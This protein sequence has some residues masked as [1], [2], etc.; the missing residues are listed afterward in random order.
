MGRPKLTDE[1]RKEARRKRERQ[2]FI[3]RSYVPK[4]FWP[5]M[6]NRHGEP[7]TKRHANAIHQNY[8]DY[9][10]ASSQCLALKNILELS[11][12]VIGEIVMPDLEGKSKQGT[13]RSYI[14]KAKTFLREKDTD[15]PEMMLYRFSIKELLKKEWPDKHQNGKAIL[16]HRFNEQFPVDVEDQRYQ[17]AP[18]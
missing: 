9:R 2:E 3:L 11:H 16:E 15:E 12:E 17:P 18:Q 14:Q 13:V 4:E 1:E 10:I 5:V 6:Y 8:I 7:S